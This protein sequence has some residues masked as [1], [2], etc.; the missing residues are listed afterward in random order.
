[1]QISS[2]IIV[3]SVV[4][5]GIVIGYLAWHRATKQ[6]KWKEV[7]TVTNL[8]I[9]PIKSCRAMDVKSFTAKNYG[10]M[11]KSGVI[12]DRTLAVVY[13]KGR[14]ARISAIDRMVLVRP[15][16]KHQNQIILEAPEMDPIKFNVPTTGCAP[17]AED[18]WRRMRIGT[19]EF[20]FIRHCT[21]CLVTTVDPETGIRDPA[22]TALK[23]LRSYRLCKP[24]EREM[25]GNSPKLS[26]E[27]LAIKEGNVSVG[28]KIYVEE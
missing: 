1:M 18:N 16:Q 14:V 15:S 9:Y 7:A 17:Y 25:C 23:T 26:V 24:E 13:N 4:S 21:R 22:Q 27:F 3:Y 12:G 5:V 8:F 19:A 2:K 20:L 11:T 10:A 6:R 28:D